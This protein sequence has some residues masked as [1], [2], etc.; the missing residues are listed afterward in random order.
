MGDTNMRYTRHDIKANFLDPVAA[1]GLTVADPWVEFHR[2]GTYPS[3]NTK[4][5]MTRAHFAG[6]NEN[7]ILCSDD[8]RGEVVDKLWYINVPE[9]DVQLNAISCGNDIDNFRKETKEVSCSG[10]T[11]VDADGN[12]LT[13]QSV[14]YT[15][16]V[17]LAD[18][19]PV[20]VSFTYSYK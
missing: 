19:F 1:E 15:K 17:G 3:W 11:I 4:S 10:V 7:D 20:V 6:D 8:Q 2:G 5:L 12:L 14:S 18:H 9:A 16:S 13:G